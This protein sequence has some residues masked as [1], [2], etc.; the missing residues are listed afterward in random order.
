MK[1]IACIRKNGKYKLEK[2]IREMQFGF[3]H[4]KQVRE[5]GAPE[6]EE[7]IVVTGVY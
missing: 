2:L 1:I 5:F 3:A 7:M 6:T 4:R